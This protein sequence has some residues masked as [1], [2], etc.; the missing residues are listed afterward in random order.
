MIDGALHMEQLLRDLRAYTMSR[1]PDSDRRTMLM[2]IRCMPSRSRGDI[3]KRSVSPNVKQEWKKP[4]VRSEGAYLKL[5]TMQ[6]R[7]PSG[8]WQA[9]RALLRPCGTRRILSKR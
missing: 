6:S 9:W 3:P 8:P 4:I 7:E 2:L 5:L 1:A